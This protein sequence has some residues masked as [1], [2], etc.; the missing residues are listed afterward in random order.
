MYETKLQ[1]TLLKFWGNLDFLQNCSKTWM[2][3]T[4][5]LVLCLFSMRYD[6]LSF[7]YQLSSK[8]CC[9]LLIKK[10]KFE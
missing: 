4:Y 5:Y 1:F 9:I 6:E 10:H 2:N 8:Q 7:K 3:I